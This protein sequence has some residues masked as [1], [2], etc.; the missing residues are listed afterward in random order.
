[1][2]RDVAEALDDVD[3][4]CEYAV[5]TASHEEVTQRFAAV[6]PGGGSSELHIMTIKL[7]GLQPL[8]A[9]GLRQQG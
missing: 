1:M 5:L 8:A 6:R 4:S 7:F 2:V 9:A 3:D